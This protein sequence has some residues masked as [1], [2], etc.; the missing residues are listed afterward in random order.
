MVSLPSGRL[1]CYQPDDRPHLMHITGRRT[2]MTIDTV[3]NK[4][5]RYSLLPTPH[6]GEQEMIAMQSGVR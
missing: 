2:L 1:R 4:D 5:D 3:F 6:G